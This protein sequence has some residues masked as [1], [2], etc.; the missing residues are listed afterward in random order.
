MKY[1]AT[2]SELQFYCFDPRLKK[3]W[4]RGI[5]SSQHEIH[6]DT[7][8]KGDI[9]PTSSPVA[10]WA[11]ENTS[12]FSSYNSVTYGGLLYSEDCHCCHCTCLQPSPELL[13]PRHTEN[14]MQLQKSGKGTKQY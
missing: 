3:G 14:H 5:L 9:T 12:L 11:V 7:L 10:L 8:P 6:G 1:S 13:W 4:V 2:Y